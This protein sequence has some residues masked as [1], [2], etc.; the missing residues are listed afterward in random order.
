[1]VRSPDADVIVV[2]AGPAGSAAA[3]RLARAGRRVILAD[4]A[5][6]PR[7]KCCGDGLTG[8]ALARLSALG[9]RSTNVES[10]RDIERATFVSPSGHAIRLPTAR[11]SRGTLAVA[12]RSSLD[13]ALIGLARE[14][15]AT[16]HEGAKLVDVSQNSNALTL[17]FD[18]LGE[19][20]APLVIGADGAW[21][22]L[23]R[24]LKPDS[25][26]ERAKWQAVRTYVEAVDGP[27]VSEAFVWFQA[28]LLPGYAWS[29]PLPGGRAN[30]GLGTLRDT[31]GGRGWMV[32]RLTDFL[33]S[34]YA[35]AALGG[36]A[37]AADRTLAWPIPTNLRRARLT[38]A[39]GR[40]LFVGD[41]TGV[42]DPMTGEGIA[43][44]LQTGELAAE[45]ILSSR[46][47]TYHRLVSRQLGGRH[48]RRQLCSDLLRKP[49]LAR[50]GIRVAGT[51]AWA[52]RQ[53]SR[54]VFD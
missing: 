51:T 35:I 49:L 6:F 25:E 16:V 44:A 36:R 5:H 27:A 9:L 4:K 11:R 17:G 23:R 31:G 37:R 50:G 33:E 21:S 26:P 54:W 40:A 20:R 42:T 34:E 48:R 39:D 2:G 8:P 32:R 29:F 19:L 14:A 46:P 15:G 3:I 12:P 10:W 22:P 30:V 18:G 28:D 24:L 53:F 13:A 52:R 45:A 47:L 41:A 38:A 7:D 1:M 43:E